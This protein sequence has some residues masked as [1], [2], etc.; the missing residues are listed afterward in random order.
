M[1]NRVNRRPKNVRKKVITKD[2]FDSLLTSTMLTREIKLPVFITKHKVNP[3]VTRIVRIESKLTSGVPNISFNYLAVAGQDAL[4]YTGLS[5]PLR[6]SV[7]RVQSARVWLESPLNLS[8]SVDSF[9]IILSEIPSGY[10]VANRGTIGSRYA[11]AG[12]EFSLF[13]RQ[14]VVATS[15]ATFIFTVQADK[16]IPAS[17]DINLVV[18]VLVEFS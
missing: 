4:D 10:S 13:V 1:N 3:R 9:G 16:T 8:V 5:S 12:M 18:D 2:N 7:M 17:T 11:S 6:Y 14:A 15:S